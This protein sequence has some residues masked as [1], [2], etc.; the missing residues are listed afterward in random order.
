MASSFLRS[1]WVPCPFMESTCLNLIKPDLPERS[2]T[3]RFCLPVSPSRVM[4]VIVTVSRGK[5]STYMKTFTIDTDN[6][7]TVHTSRKAARETGAGVFASE[8]QFANLIGPDNKRL[9]EIWNSLTGVK[10]VT[11]F[12]NRKLAAERIWKALQSLGEQTAAAPASEPQIEAAAGEAIPGEFTVAEPVVIEAEVVP[13]P[14]Q[15][16]PDT[17]RP[18][19]DVT[20]QAEIEPLALTADEPIEVAE[21][22]ADT[23][24]QAPQ[25][26]PAKVVATENANPAK[27]PRKAKK[28]P[29]P[30]STAG[31]REGSKMAQVVAMLK[32][33]NGATL[34]EI[35]TKMGWQKHT[36]RGFMAGAMKKA[37]YTVESF[38][39]E[40]GARSYRINP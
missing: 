11:K 4:N 20:L 9:V 15:V 5:E 10:P 22:V 26:A 7:I 29:K 36:V 27:K 19:E 39:S 37:G 2:I 30:E 17:A 25:E 13:E 1:N 12:A 21:R 35:M 31:P 23:G 3:R 8:E 34:E 18:L 38:K 6:N 24:A 32:T 40:A 16:E 14:E 28:A 33:A